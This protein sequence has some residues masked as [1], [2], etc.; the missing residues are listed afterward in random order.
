MTSIKSTQDKFE[1]STY[2]N[3]PNLRGLNVPNEWSKDQLEEY[4]R[5]KNDIIYF[6]ENYVKIISLDEGRVLF[7][8]YDYQK[9]LLYRFDQYRNNVA[10][11]PR[12]SGKSTVV[13]AFILH[14]ILF[15]N[16]K[17]AAF[18]A[19]KANTA[20]EILSRVK[21]AYEGI[22]KWMQQG[23]KKFN[24]GS[25]ELENGS[26]CLAAATSSGSIRGF[27][28]N[29]LFM[30]E[31]AHIPPNQ[32]QAFF[33]S[34]YPTISSGKTTKIIMVSTPNGMNHFY[35][36]VVKAQKNALEPK[37]PKNRFRLTTATWK[38]V[39]GRDEQWA[40]DEIANTSQEDFDQ[41]QECVFLGASNTLIESV[42]LNRLMEH[43]KDVKAV[44]YKFDQR[45]L[46]FKKPQEDHLYFATCDP[47]EGLNQDYST[48]SVFDITQFPFEQVATFRCNKTSELLLAP[49]LSTIGRYYNNAH[50]LVESNK[51]SVVLHSLN[52]E[53]EYP[54]IISTSVKTRKKSEFGLQ[55]NKLSKR[56]GCSRLKEMIE[57]RKLQINDAVTVQE[58]FTFVAGTN[59]YEAEEGSHDDMVMSLVIFAYYINSP[60]YSMIFDDDVESFKQT[61]IANHIDQIQEDFPV[62][63]VV[64]SGDD[65][66]FFNPDEEDD[67]FSSNFFNGVDRV[68]YD[69]R[70][71][72]D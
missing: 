33:R 67:E 26:G 32:F 14:Y 2:L 4:F 62:E 40:R 30:D 6:V 49:L 22:P 56:M 51:G 18:L 42:H 17:T 45:M 7:K 12:Q 23:V 11:L 21:E 47:S 19:H 54:N 24:E 5:C 9:K 38:D 1:D 68:V 43:T 44:D 41:E 61:F 66:S 15:N 28:I 52:Y 55:M 29:I 69:S 70:E 63:P 27:S 31:V 57:D 53:F 8:P 64:D 35:D 34:V 46:I 13:A 65:M 72:L 16:Q 10:V 59:S 36:I 60:D 3:N 37:P 39:P 71:L 48:V 20:R 25:I 58:L 50:V